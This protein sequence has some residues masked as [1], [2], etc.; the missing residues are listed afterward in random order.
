LKQRFSP[1]TEGKSKERD[2]QVGVA[3][4]V[5]EAEVVPETETEYGVRH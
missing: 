3:E 4:V 5:V 1:L 2:T